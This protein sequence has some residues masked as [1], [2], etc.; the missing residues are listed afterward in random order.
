MVSLLN[1]SQ[2]VEYLKADLDNAV[3]DKNEQHTQVIQL[4]QENMNLKSQLDVYTKKKKNAKK[5][6]QTPSKVQTVT[7]AFL[8]KIDNFFTNSVMFHLTCQKQ[9]KQM[10]MIPSNSSRVFRQVEDK[11]QSYLDNVGAK[12]SNIQKQSSW[13]DVQNIRLTSELD[14]CKTG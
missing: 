13:L 10:N 1:F 11:F 5:T 3:K 2:T 9:E 6:L 7:K 12:V 14:K 4:R 8:T